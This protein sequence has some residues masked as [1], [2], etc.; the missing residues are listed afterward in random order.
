MKNGVYIGKYIVGLLLGVSIAAYGMNGHEQIMSKFKEPIVDITTL[1]P[2][3]RDYAF[4]NAMA[5]EDLHTDW[6]F[7]NAKRLDER[8]PVKSSD[9][10]LS[11]DPDEIPTLNISL[12]DDNNEIQLGKKKR[13]RKRK[14]KKK[15]GNSVTQD[16]IVALTNLDH[17]TNTFLRADVDGRISQEL[18]NRASALLVLKNL[19]P[20]TYKKEW[21]YVRDTYKQKQQATLVD[22]QENGS[23][24]YHD[25]DAAKPL[26]LYHVYTKMI[27]YI[28]SQV[29]NS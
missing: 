8:E 3:G 21:H 2:S 9:E 22:I 19:S 20:E 29:Y 26:I 5:R 27:A 11:P 24:I 23:A 12:E 17:I 6:L 15:K 16:N 1:D 18:T 10:E 7:N 25:I 13:V 14:N 4:F 28:N